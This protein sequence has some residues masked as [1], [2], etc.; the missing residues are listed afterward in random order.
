M[1]T[2][3][4]TEHG[5]IFASRFALR[6]NEFDYDDLSPCAICGT[7]VAPAPREGNKVDLRYEDVGGAGGLVCDDCGEKFAPELHWL[8]L[9]GRRHRTSEL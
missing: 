5:A 1:S 8:Q 9:C 6:T 3:L 7:D 4:V 2:L